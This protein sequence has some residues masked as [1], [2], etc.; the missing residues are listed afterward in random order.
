MNENHEINVNK[1]NGSNKLEPSIQK[2]NGR[3]LYLLR[4]RIRERVNLEVEFDL[5]FDFTLHV[6][7]FCCFCHKQPWLLAVICAFFCN[8]IA[9]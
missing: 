5:A 9:S 4:S 3:H 8:M 1:T 2:D 6:V 7:S